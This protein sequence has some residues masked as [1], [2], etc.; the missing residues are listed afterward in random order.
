[1]VAAAGVA[2]AAIF[3][4]APAEA[5]STARIHL[6]HGIP[7]TDVDVEAG[8][9]NVFTAFKFGEKKDLSSLAGQT[10]RGLKVKAAG[11]ST[12][13]IDAGDVAL[14][15]SG[16]Y[17]VVA[18]LNADGKPSLAVFQND[19]SRIA[20]G[21]G[22]LIVRHAAAA[23]AVDVKANGQTAFAGVVNGKEGKADLPVGT[24]SATVT[25]AGAATP[26]VIGPANLRIADGQALIVYAVGSLSA[27][28]VSVLT[29]TIDGLGT[30][31]ARVNTGNTPIDD[32]ARG[33]TW[34]LV[35]LL[36]STALAS[37]GVVLA[38]RRVR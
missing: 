1:M 11:T 3:A 27:N 8:G 6:L 24:I 22:R 38:R 19:T 33:M 15:A 29:E 21:S 34:A 25:P 31:P 14:P 32:G 2:A 12:V 13:A 9:A 4:A 23:P 20:A 5:Q 30:Q 17:T 10:L 37:G 7:A 28:N 16:N 26:N 36:A 35:A 18:H